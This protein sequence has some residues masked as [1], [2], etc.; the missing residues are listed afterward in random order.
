MMQRFDLITI[1]GGSGGIATAV[2]AAKHGA[3]VAIAEPRELG[4]TCVN[5]GCVP[6]KAMWYAA[7]I[8]QAMRWAPDYGFDVEMKGFDWQVMKAARDQYIANIHGFYDRLLSSHG[9]T[10][11]KGY[12]SF[13]DAHT[14]KVGDTRVQARH[15]VIASGGRPVVPDIP[16]AELGVTSDEFFDWTEQPRRVLVLGSGYIAV[17][18]AGVLHGLGSE[19]TLAIRKERVLRSFDAMLGDALMEQMQ[20]DGIR[21]LKLHTPEKLEATDRGIRAC[22]RT[23]PEECGEYEGFD[24]VIWAVGRRP[25]TDALALDAAGV[26]TDGRGYILVDKFQNTNV[27]GVYAIGDVTPMA[28]L[29]PVA[30]AA[31]RRLARRLFNGEH[32]LYLDSDLIPTVVFSHPPIGTVGLSEAAAIARFGESSVTT[33]TSRFTPM[34]SALTSKRQPA[35]MKLVCR[36]DPSSPE[37]TSKQQ[38]VGLHVIGTGADEMLQGFAVAMRMGAS[39]ADFDNTVAIHPTAAEEFVTMA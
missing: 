33:Y 30:I 7:E 26:E 25:A 39:K 31:G 29:T 22:F 38:V 11:L 1:G 17:E 10:H 6:K 28:Q 34:L 21:L 32:D 37:D 14:L 18:L 9:I 2:R 15:V 35:E 8:A 3:R 19:V 4:G 12:A 36:L 20:A 13:E 16:G 24:A 27:D 5:R 23:G